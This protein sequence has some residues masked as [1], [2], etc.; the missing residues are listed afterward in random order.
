MTVAATP[1]SNPSPP[2]IC[3]LGGGFG[4]LYAAL[5]LARAREL[6]GWQILLV[7]ASDRFLFS[8]LLYELMTGELETWEIAPP[9]LRLLQGSSVEFCRDTVEAVDFNRRR[10]RLRERGDLHYSALILGLGVEGVRPPN[11]DVL[12]FRTLHDARRLEAELQ[13]LLPQAAPTVAIIGGGPS[14]VELACKLGDRL[15]DRGNVHLIDRSSQLLRQFAPASR[16]SAHRALDERSVRV[17]L[18]TS[19]AQLDGSLERGF[20]LTLAG[21]RNTVELPADLVIW[22]AGTRVSKLGRSLDCPHSDRGKCLVTASLQLRDRPEVFVLG[23][24]AE[25][26]DAPLPDTAQVVYQQ[27]GRAAANLRAYLRQ[28]RPKPFRY[29]HLGE[30]M[31]LGVGVGLVHSFG[32]H[33]NGTLGNLIRRLVYTQR[34]PTWRHRLRVL[35]HQ[36][37]GLGKSPKPSLEP[38][39]APPSTLSDTHDRSWD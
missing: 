14:G 15:G 20:Q 37:Q 24:L 1:R 18:N 39:P 12:G 5:S 8:P 7:D 22:T 34:L 38:L 19:V 4:G 33:I 21:D 10:V 3:I 28:R 26:E 23:D 2:R 30:M 11:P 35:R 32:I 9:Y 6:Q 17:S 16:R 25:R 29:L 27:A 31:T 13:R 36:L